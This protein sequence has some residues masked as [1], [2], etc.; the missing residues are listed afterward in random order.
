MLCYST[1]S[2][3]LDHSDY[4]LF[5]AKPIILPFTMFISKRMPEDVVIVFDKPNTL[6]PKINK[7]AYNIKK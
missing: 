1:D 6:I 5:R 3:E 7:I 4:E 2:S